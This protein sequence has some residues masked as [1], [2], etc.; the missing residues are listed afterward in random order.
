M[1]WA[2]PDP[3]EKITIS[4][5]SALLSVCSFIGSATNISVSFVI[6]FSIGLPRLWARSYCDKTR[7]S[8]TVV[9]FPLRRPNLYYTMDF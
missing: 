8:G 6:L 9:T 1:G 7:L 2:D 4:V 5:P 3:I